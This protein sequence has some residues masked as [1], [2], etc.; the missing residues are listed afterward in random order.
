MLLRTL[1]VV[2]VLIAAAPHASAQ[3]ENPEYRT[4][5]TEAVQE[6]D[7]GRYPE[8][9]ALFRRA[10]A[11]SPNA[12]TLR[13]IGLSSFEMSDYV[14]AYRSLNAALSETTRPLTAEQ[15]AEVE[16]VLTRTSRF[17]GF[18]RLS[19]TPESA[20]VTVD[21][22]EAV[23]AADGRVLLGM[24]S[25]EIVARADGYREAR[26]T[27]RVEGGEDTELALELEAQG[28]ADPVD[29]GD[30]GD[31][32][33]PVAPATTAF[34][35]TPG[36]VTLSIGAAAAAASVI[37]G[38]AGWL[39]RQDELSVCW[40]REPPCDQEAALL[41]ERD[42][43]IAITITLAIGGVAAIVAGVALLAGGGSSTNS[44]DLPCD[45][46]G[47]SLRCEF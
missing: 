29:P 10:H 12:R 38:L 3:A 24:G 46:V 23:T 34:D 33:D 22:A 5:I 28:G 13:G 35:P 16:A 44:A 8:A 20:R 47:S 39:T 41:T 36:I 37:V 27:V 17:L 18:Y 21:G 32:D 6:F 7:A 43:S 15:R 9:R 14:E 11:I 40:S 31:R 42:A 19:V 4:L 1:T 26:S 25:H 30:P 45:L 2:L